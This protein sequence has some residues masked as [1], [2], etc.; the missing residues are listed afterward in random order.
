MLVKKGDKGR[1]VKEIQ[2][3][4]DFHGFWTYHKITD[5]F[6]SVTEEAVRN[7]QLVKGLRNDGAVG[8]QTLAVLL[9]G[10]DSD[11][12]TIDDAP[13]GVDKDNKLNHLGEYT[14]PTGLVINKVYLDDDEYVKDYGKIEPR[15]F[16]IHHTAGGH[17]PVRTV[18]NWNT[19][20]RGRVATQYCIGGISTKDGNTDHD[21]MVVECFP[22]NY[23]GWHL[24]KVGNFNMSKYSAAVEINSYGYLT[25]KGDKYYNAY[26]G[27]V[28]VDMVCDL[29]YKFKGRQYWHRYTD[30]QMEAI[31]GLLEHI[32][33]T[34][35][36]IPLQAGIPQLL[37]NGVHPRDAFAFDSLAYN[38]KIEGTWSHTSVR[39]GKMD[40]YPDPR[41]VE[42]LKRL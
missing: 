34:Y 42:I 17:N 15:W 39:N 30:K 18:G 32:A 26:G 8:D 16:F 25:K 22:D 23:I 33:Y 40:A 28:P 19:D 3:L 10:V 29:G 37:K 12:Y 5:F 4:L 2:S 11:D 14:S 9:E 6:G 41:L 7:F 38:G 21:G 13:S 31:E 27:L 20:T 35:P 24:G 1:N 36:H